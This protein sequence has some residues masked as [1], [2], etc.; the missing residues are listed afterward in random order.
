MP[1]PT[2]RAVVITESLTGGTLPAAFSGLEDRRY[3]HLLDEQTPIEIIE[4]TVPADRAPAL[5]LE[6]AAVLKPRLFYAHLLD[7]E[8]M[9]VAFPHTVVAIRRGD[10]AAIAHAQA[11]GSLFG[12][13][14]EQMRFAEMF[15]T[16][17]PDAS[18]QPEA[19]AR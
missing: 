15:D 3:A 8:R 1:E 6:L 10:A 7:G 18:A 5:A 13:P 14:D 9:L 16:D 2:L 11:V 4:L 19:T 17:H 12:I